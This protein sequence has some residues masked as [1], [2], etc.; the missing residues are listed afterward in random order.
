MNN[1]ETTIKEAKAAGLKRY[2]TGKTCKY[3]HVAERRVSNQECIECKRRRDT[4]YQA[5]NTEKKHIR[6]HVYRAA[7]LETERA[8]KRGCYAANSEKLSAYVRARRK[9]NPERRRSI[10]R[11][12]YANNSGKHCARSMARY[13]RKLRAMPVWACEQTIADFY[14]EARYQGMQVDHMVPLKHPL[15]CG[16]HVEDN[17]QLLTAT[18]NIQKSNRYTP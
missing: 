16:L 4:A 7:H 12:S 2:F 18:E 17:L 9:A 14:T 11:A 10:D 13:T 15:V 3:G 5:A 6:Y 1:Q 8:R